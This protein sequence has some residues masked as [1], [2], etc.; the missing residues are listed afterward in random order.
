MKKDA[1]VC[2]GLVDKE[3]LFQFEGYECLDYVRSCLIRESNEK[4][5][6]MVQQIYELY[7]EMYWIV[8]DDR[9]TRQ[10]SDDFEAM[11]RKYGWSEFYDAV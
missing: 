6:N 10:L 11:A 1:M 8:E 3:R 4:I 9:D 2:E 5:A 7:A